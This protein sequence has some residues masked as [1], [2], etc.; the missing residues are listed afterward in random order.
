MSGILYFYRYSLLLAIF[1]VS[2]SFLV[3]Y[4]ISNMR[5]NEKEIDIRVKW[6]ES[7]EQLETRIFHINK[8]KKV[9][10]YVSTQSALLG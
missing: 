1:V 5:D 7:S 4:F 9:D 10:I 2:V 6:S 3:Y 8:K